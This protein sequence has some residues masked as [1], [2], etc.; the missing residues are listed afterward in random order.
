MSITGTYRHGTITL[1]EQPAW[2][3]EC[4]VEISPRLEQIG[5]SEEEQ[6]T[7]PESTAAWIAWYRQLPPAHL[8]ESDPESFTWMKQAGQY[9]PTKLNDIEQLFP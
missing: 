5:C 9:S 7:D 4:E 8:A 2:P 6:G 1:H 3:E